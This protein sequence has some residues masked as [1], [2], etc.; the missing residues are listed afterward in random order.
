VIAALGATRRVWATRAP[1]PIAADR[2]DYRFDL[3]E[4]ARRKLFSE[5]VADE[6]EWRKKAREHFKEAWRAEDDRAAFERD[7]VRWLA[8]RRGVNVT[9]AYLVLDEGVRKRWPGPGGAPVDP[10]VVPLQK[11]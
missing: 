2:G 8:G 11:K 5:L 9:V 3:D 4:A 10:N 1:A 6:P 7:H